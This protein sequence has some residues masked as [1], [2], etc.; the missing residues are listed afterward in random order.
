MQYVKL[1]SGNLIIEF[2]NKWTGEETVIVNG[3][4]VSKESSIWGT[5]HYFTAVEQGHNNRYVLTT[6]VDGMTMQVMVDLSKNGVLIHQNVPVPFGSG[7][8]KVTNKAKKKGMSFLSE[9]DLEEALVEFE[10][11][12]SV[13]PHDPEVHFHMACAYSILERTLEGFESLRLSVKYHLRDKDMILSHDM[14]AFI[15]MNEA[16]EDFVESDF[17]EYD[18]E[19]V[20]KGDF[21][22]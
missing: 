11:A 15:R 20:K 8:R 21:K 6:K 7:N 3:Q 12:L 2:H 16:F 18:E 4:V 5:Q 17:L 22:F 1:I 13:D 14:L 19:A 9:Y 10:K